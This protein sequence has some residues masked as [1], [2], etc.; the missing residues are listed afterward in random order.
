[1]KILVV[2]SGGREHALVWKIRQSQKVDEIY[3]APGNA[4]TAEI[5]KNIDIKVDEIDKLANFAEENGI[6]LTVVGP[7]LPLVMG[8]T[9][10]FK[11]RGLRVFGPDKNCSQF[12]G[13]KAFTK[14]FL[15]KYGIPTAAYGEYTDM[16]KAMADLDSFGY[17]V[18]IKADG[19]AA[20]KG[21][22]IATD[23]STAE[24][25]LR[26]M[27]E[28]KVFGDS[29]NKVVL[30]EFLEGTEASVLCFVDGESIIPMESARDY[31]RIFDGDEGP[32]TGGM[33]TY[34]PNELFDD[35]LK[36]IMDETVLKPIIKGFLEENMDYRGVLFIGLMIKDNVTKVLEFNVRFGDPETESVLMRMENDLVDVFEK[37]IDGNLKSEDLKWR[38]EKALCVVVASGGYPEQ[39]Q[40]GLEIS[41]LDELE[42]VVVFHCGTKRSKDKILT[43]GG[44]VLAVTGLGKDF[45]EAREKVYG[46]L[47][48]V[49]FQGMQY[50]KDISG[51]NK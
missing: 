5:A 23:R 35:G 21:V 8:I 46:Q 38:R 28:N 47:K 22:V 39:Y 42:D 26:D 20:G 40:K 25:T 41:G 49:K 13:S 2:G 17:P 12:E 45:G 10:I 24:K 18:V 15:Q 36:S 3:C 7:E 48:K 34:S 33:G 6:D 16:E 43:D 9:D 11:R 30:E 4:G 37:V 44:R 14:K 51:S 27:M 50:R 29:G 19:L 32:N 1:M 31:K